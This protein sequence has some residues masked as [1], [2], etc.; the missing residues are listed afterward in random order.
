MDITKKCYKSKY[1]RDTK[2]FMKKK[3][4]KNRNIEGIDI[5]ICPKKT[6]KT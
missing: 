5:R 4:R 1:A 2:I 3:K 6:N